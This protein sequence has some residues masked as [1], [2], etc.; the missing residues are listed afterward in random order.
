MMIGNVMRY[1]VKLAADSV[2]VKP[3][4][5][6]PD[7]LATKIMTDE[8]FGIIAI[9]DPLVAQYYL[10]PTKS[11]ESPIIPLVD[12]IPA[13]LLT[14]LSTQPLSAYVFLAEHQRTMHAVVQI[15]TTGEYNL[16]KS[17]L[18]SGLY[19]ITSTKAPAAVNAA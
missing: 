4:F 1:T 11:A 12:N 7:V 9:P 14:R 19:F 15:H 17:L 6:I 13:H 3:S 2:G 8:S 16:F 5:P 10:Q 18:E